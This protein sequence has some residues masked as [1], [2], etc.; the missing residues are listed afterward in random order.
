MKKNFIL[1]PSQRKLFCSTAK[2]RHVVGNI[3]TGKTTGIMYFTAIVAGAFKNNLIW[4][5]EPSV[6]VYMPRFIDMLD[7]L[8]Y[9]YS[10]SM[11]ERYIVLENGT[12]ILF[13]VPTP[14]RLCSYG[15]ELGM[16]IIENVDEFE[17]KLFDL[18]R[19][20]LRRDT[21]RQ[22]DNFSPELFS[23]FS[24][25]WKRIAITSSYYK[26]EEW[27]LKL[28]RNNPDPKFEAIELGVCDNK[29]LADLGLPDEMKAKYLTGSWDEVSR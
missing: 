4:F 2:Y 5:G 10:M 22:A 24:D 20:R 9:Q 26:T 6:N 29:H 1:T 11:S 27:V 7:I 23:I 28:W 14:D 12:K 25:S 3:A 21:Y 15:L 13:R 19:C 8:G 16:F 18:L 17:P